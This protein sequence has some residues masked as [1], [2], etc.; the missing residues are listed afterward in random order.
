LMM[1]RVAK[2]GRGRNPA[3]S[4]Q[5]LLERELRRLKASCLRRR[6]GAGDGG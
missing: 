6:R 2:R 4:G 5:A 3:S 1:S